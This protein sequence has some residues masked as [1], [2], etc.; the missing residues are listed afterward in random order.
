VR[1]STVLVTAAAMGAAAV[2]LHACASAPQGSSIGL[3]PT[4]VAPG[5]LGLTRHADLTGPAQLPDGRVLYVSDL[6]KYAI[7]IFKYQHRSW[8][9]IGAITTGISSPAG[10]WVDK[11]RNFYVANFFGPNV[12]EYASSGNLIFTYSSGLKAP[13]DVTTDRFGDV[14]AT[15][16]T[17]QTI[18]EYPQGRNFPLTCSLPEVPYGVA[19]DK[20]GDVFV[21]QLA[22]AE[23]VEYQSGLFK[24][25][26]TGAVLPVT[27]PGAYGIAIDPQGN[28][29]VCS[30]A[31][32]AAV[33]IIAP[34][35]TSIT[36]TLGSGW[37]DPLY[38]TI[39]K[40][41][42]QAYVS[43]QQ[44]SYVVKVVSYPSGALLATLGGANGL[45]TPFAAVDSNNYVP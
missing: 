9:K 13:V 6:E 28:L 24:S 10:N 29:V 11:K 41:G 16:F 19:V 31:S 18:T 1:I 34:P 30:F 32:P 5:F 20:G 15:D 38:V 27:V 25:G 42:T 14:Y 3:P 21:T 22:S 40:A 35:Y 4:S 26:C 8:T 39:N 2:L 7:E 33:D 43:D 45:G 17:N 36:G 12:T 44:K 23:I 37:G